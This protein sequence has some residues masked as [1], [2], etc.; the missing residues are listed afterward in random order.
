MSLHSCK[1]I[2]LFV[3]FIFIK[4]S[5]GIHVVSKD[6]SRTE[7]ASVY[8]TLGPLIGIYFLYFV[9]IFSIFTIPLINLLL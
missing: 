7:L 2:I 3:C 8:T 5:D 1:F 9:I 4:T 6:G